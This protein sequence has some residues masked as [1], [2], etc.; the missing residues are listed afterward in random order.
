MNITMRK[1]PLDISR[2]NV[3]LKQIIKQSTLARQFKVVE[4]LIQQYGYVLVES[5]N[6][7][8]TDKIL[9]DV[10]LME[11]LLEELEYAQTAARLANARCV[12][13]TSFDEFITTDLGLDLDEIAKVTSEISIPEDQF[14]D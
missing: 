1:Q 5:K 12:K 8:S 3:N 9:I 2:I 10:N 13:G 4:E 7:E 14:I 11:N 6:S